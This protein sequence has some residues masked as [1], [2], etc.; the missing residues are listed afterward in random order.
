[1]VKRLGTP[2][3]IIGKYKGKKCRVRYPSM[4]K[5]YITHTF[6]SKKDAEEYIAGLGAWQRRRAKITEI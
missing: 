6:S 1:M 5:G 2:R 3:V 4:M